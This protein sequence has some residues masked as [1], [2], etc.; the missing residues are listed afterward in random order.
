MVFN[1]TLAHLLELEMVLRSFP[2][3]ALELHKGLLLADQSP[4][5][6]F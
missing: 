6:C 2:F 5:I 3:E 4:H 1:F